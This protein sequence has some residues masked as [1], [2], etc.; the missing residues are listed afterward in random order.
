M[1]KLTGV[2]VAGLFVLGL[3]FTSCNKDDDMKPIEPPTH[4]PTEGIEDHLPEY[5]GPDHLPEETPVHLPED[6]RPEHLPE[7]PGPDHLPD[8]PVHLPEDGST[9]D[10]A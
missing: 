7:Y 1:K 9:V 6:Q 10:P 3:S 4:L 8:A 5:P 2:L